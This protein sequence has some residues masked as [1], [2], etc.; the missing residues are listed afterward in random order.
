VVALCAAA[1]LI[2]AFLVTDAGVA[3]DTR[4]PAGAQAL[5]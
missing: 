2:V 3:Q 4:I 1:L 5:R